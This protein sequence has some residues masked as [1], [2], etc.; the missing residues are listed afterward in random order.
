[1]PPRCSD[2]T[3]GE[4]TGRVADPSGASVPGAV[5]TLINV[6][7]NGVRATTSTSSGDY[8][9]PAVA[10]GFYNLKTEHP[11]FKSATSNNIE[12][13][14]QQTVRLDISLQVGQISESVEV[15]GLAELLQAENASV[16]TVIENKAVTELPL[17]GRSY[18]NLVA[19]AANVDTLSPAS[20]QAGS[21]QGGDRASQSISAAGQRIM[22]DYF[23]LDGVNNTDPNFLTYVVLPSIDAIQ[24]FKVQTGIYPAEFGHEATQ[25]NVLTKSGGNSYH[26]ALFDFVRNDKFDAIPYSFSTSHPAKSPFKWND[27]GFVVSGPVRIPKVFNGRDRLFFM[28]NDEWKTQRADSQGVYTVPTPAM[29]AGDLS[30]PGGDCLRSKHGGRRSD[31]DAVPEQPDSHQPHR[32]DL[33][34]VFEVLQLLQPAGPEQKLHAVQRLPQQPGRVHTSHGLRRIVEI[35]VDRPL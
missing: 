33:A 29:F 15:S 6:S 27:Y 17:N 26:G 3:L 24:E 5:I 20:G 10:P 8:A 9:F 34:K 19:L 35:A 18:L 4:I 11:G 30:A 14:V 16:G 23:T 25:I 7:T 2:K 32:S 31:E 28:A 13:Q 22:F 21:R 1:M 12:V